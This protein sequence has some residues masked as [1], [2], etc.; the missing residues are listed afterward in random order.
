MS[1]LKLLETISVE[2]YLEGEKDAS[3]KHEYVDGRVFALA[4]ASDTHNRVAG[5]IF[6]QLW[7]AAAQKGCRIYMSDIKVRALGSRFYYPD[8]M[9]VC[10]ET[11]GDPYIKEKPCL[12]VEILS[13]STA[14]TDRREKVDTYL[15]LP[16]LDAYV[17][18]DSQMKQVEAFARTPEGWRED[19]WKGDGTVPFACLDTTLSFD[20]IYRGLELPDFV[21]PLG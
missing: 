17:L 5:N 16:T 9:V 10:D 13:R 7:D 6:A 12:I 15:S 19:H 18:V 4:G 8:V 14:S 3:I 1:A 20:A 2:E 11:D 21:E